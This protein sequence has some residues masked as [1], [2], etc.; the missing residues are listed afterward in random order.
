MN[1]LNSKYFESPQ[2]PTPTPANITHAARIFSENWIQILTAN[3]FDQ[4]IEKID[5]IPKKIDFAADKSANFSSNIAVKNSKQTTQ[6]RKADQ[7]PIWSRKLAALT[8]IITNL[9]DALE[10]SAKCIN[11]ALN[12]ANLDQ[13]LPISK[14]L[15]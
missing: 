14:I 1:G 2:T 9:E 3:E 8:K 11:Y 7:S 10:N 13:K 12:L 4:P 5:F 6:K 15:E